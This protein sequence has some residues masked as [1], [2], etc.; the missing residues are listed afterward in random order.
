MDAKPGT[1]KL[2]IENGGERQLKAYLAANGV[3]SLGEY[4]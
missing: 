4:G 3:M 2:G 1:T